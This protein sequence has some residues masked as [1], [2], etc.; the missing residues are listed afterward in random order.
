MEAKMNLSSKEDLAFSSFYSDS[1][2][3]KNN[4]SYSKLLRRSNSPLVVKSV[5]SPKRFVRILRHGKNNMVN[6]KFILP[7]IGSHSLGKFII[8]VDPFQNNK[9]LTFKID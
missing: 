2:S 1:F 8:E 7:R 3:Y 9:D 6:A 5:V 4:V